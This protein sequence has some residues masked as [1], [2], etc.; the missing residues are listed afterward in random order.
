[1]QLSSYRLP[2]FF[3][4]HLHH[5][6]LISQL[7]NVEPLQTE[8]HPSNKIYVIYRLP[9]N[10]MDLLKWKKRTTEYCIEHTHMLDKNIL[11]LSPLLKACCSFILSIKSRI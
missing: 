4:F 6:S 1:M 5:G 3:S 7:L 11:N 8:G 2:L 9:Y 10:F